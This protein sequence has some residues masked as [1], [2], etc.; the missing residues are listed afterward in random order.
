MTR[1]LESCETWSCWLSDRILV[2]PQVQ[3]ILE[4]WLH[5]STPS[6]CRGLTTSLSDWVAP[7]EE[8]ASRE[9]HSSHFKPSS[10]SSP[11]QSPSDLGLW[12]L[13]GQKSPPAV[14]R[15]KG[16]DHSPADEDKWL[17]RKRSQAQVTG[18]LSSYGSYPVILLCTS[19][20]YR[21]LL[22]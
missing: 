21:A 7:H 8:K 9:E 12:V 5:P 1:I 2:S 19:C 6:A 22:V 11:F 13:P 20:A 18:Q 16:E 14:G 15:S 17:L 3:A 4:A 10:S